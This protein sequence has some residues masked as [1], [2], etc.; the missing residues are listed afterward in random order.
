MDI[1]Q[2]RIMD[3]TQEI[4]KL[5]KRQPGFINEPPTLSN[6]GISGHML[7]M[8]LARNITTTDVENMTAQTAQ[9]I[10]YSYFYIKTGVNKLPMLIRPIMLDMVA[11]MGK[12][13]VQK[14]QEILICHGLLPD[15]YHPGG[16]IDDDTRAAAFEA[17]KALG[18]ELIRMLVTRYIIYFESQAK[19]DADRSQL[20]ANIAR[21]EAFLPCPA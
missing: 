3:I 14:L 10:Y 13:A 7:S 20:P 21:A 11:V 2:E 6:H 4:K 5:V 16:K 8:Y 9:D 12:R 18:N 1:T 15:D 17:E 19:S